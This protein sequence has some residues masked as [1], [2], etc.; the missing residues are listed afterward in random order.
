MRQGTVLCLSS[1]TQNRP[2]SHFLLTTALNKPIIFFEV[3]FMP[4]T[5]RKTS[6]TGIYH[7]ILRGINQQNIFE[8]EEDK[9]RFLFILQDTK[10]TC[11]YELYA[12]ALMSNHVHLLLKTGDAPLEEI[13]KRIGGKYVYWYNLKYQRSGHLFQDRF[14]S[15]PVEDDE[16]LLTVICYIHYNPLRA[17][18]SDSLDYK[19]SSFAD[20]FE[21]GDGSVSQGLETQNRP[22]SQPITD[23]TYPLQ[24][25]GAQ[26]FIAFHDAPTARCVMEINELT[27]P[28]VTEEQARRILIKLCGAES[29]AD[30][31]RLPQAEQAEIIA[32]ARKKGVSI[33]Q[34]NRLT[35]LSRGMIERWSK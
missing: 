1:E 30:F 12:Y 13:F 7:V 27:K 15:E 17:G 25:F 5:A 26:R 33:R 14:K 28:Y 3:I 21:T 2:L 10:K 24:T 29:T 11:G 6:S 8:D 9:T 16:Y 35:G 23:T 20:Y 32:L 18:L 4:R 19:Y 31:Q 34:L 22:L